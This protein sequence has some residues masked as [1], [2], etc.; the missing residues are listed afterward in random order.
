VGK[1]PHGANLLLRVRVPYNLK[2]PPRGRWETK[3]APQNAPSW[4]ENTQNA[5]SVRGTGGGDYY[6]KGNSRG[7]IVDSGSLTCGLPEK[8]ISFRRKWN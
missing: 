1:S 6:E 7:K 5:Q 3:G 2:V 8:R 4:G